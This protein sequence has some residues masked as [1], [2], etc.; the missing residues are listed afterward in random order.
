M[1]FNCAM[2]DNSKEPIYLLFLSE[3]AIDNIKNTELNWKTKDKKAKAFIQNLYQNKLTQ[4]PTCVACIEQLEPKV[5]GIKFENCVKITDEEEPLRWKNAK[6]DCKV[7]KFSAQKELRCEECYSDKDIYICMI[8]GYVACGRYQNADSKAHWKEK[9]HSLAMFHNEIAIWDYNRDE[10]VHRINTN[11][12]I[13]CESN[14]DDMYD[15]QVKDMA[16]TISQ[17]YTLL[18][19]EQLEQQQKYF[20]D[21]IKVIQEEKAYRRLNEELSDIYQKN[22]SLKEETI[23]IDKLDKKNKKKIKKYAEKIETLNTKISEMNEYKITAE[24]N[25]KF[26]EEQ[27]KLDHDKVVSK[28]EMELDQKI[29]KEGKQLL[30]LKAK[31]EGLYCKL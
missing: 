13:F 3:I 15:K 12:D 29:D 19:C 18:L 14:F 1:E 2:L 24:S 20:N 28:E 27:E 4:I 21:K 30:A 31:L 9:K 7:Q 10:F 16:D 25:I 17:N 23:N 22:E 8:C 6:K 5:T 11:N 26:L